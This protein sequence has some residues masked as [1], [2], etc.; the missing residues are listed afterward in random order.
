MNAR[1]RKKQRNEAVTIAKGYRRSRSRML[2]ARRTLLDMAASGSTDT[3]KKRK[4]GKVY[5]YHRAIVTANERARDRLPSEEWK[6]A[7][8]KS[9]F[10]GKSITDTALECYISERS[11]LRARR[12]FLELLADEVGM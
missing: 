10:Q 11:V 4:L 12:A 1:E 8:D 7:V 9:F 3:E 2:K 6:K 5:A